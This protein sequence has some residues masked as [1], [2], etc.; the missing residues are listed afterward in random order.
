MAIDLTGITN[1]NEFY[2]HHYLS[3]VLEN[4]LKDLFAR[5]EAQKKEKDI[6]L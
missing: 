2:T 6:G 1:K 4:D 5:W 3:A